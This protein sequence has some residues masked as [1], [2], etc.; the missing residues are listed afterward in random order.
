MLQFRLGLQMVNAS[1]GTLYNDAILD[2]RVGKEKDQ[3]YYES[4]LYKHTGNKSP[5]PLQHAVGCNQYQFLNMP[6]RPAD[7]FAKDCLDEKN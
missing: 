5:L 4:N 2:K 1:K 3:L 6:H 7:Q